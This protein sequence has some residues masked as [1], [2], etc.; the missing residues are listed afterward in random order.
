MFS[1]FIAYLIV[2]YHTILSLF[3]Y[4]I[5]RILLYFI[6]FTSLR[7]YF[8]LQFTFLFRSYFWLNFLYFQ[9]LINISLLYNCHRF[10]DYIIILIITILFQF[11]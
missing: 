11:Y 10:C 8:N 5:L 9:I 4:F 2:F 6:L 7:V 1:Y 3:Y